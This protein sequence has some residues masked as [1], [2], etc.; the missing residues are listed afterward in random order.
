MSDKLT[1]EQIDDLP[2]WAEENLVHH[3]HGGDYNND[4]GAVREILTRA[5]A[6]IRH[7]QEQTEIAL[8]LKHA[9]ED[10]LGVS[11]GVVRELNAKLAQPTPAPVPADDEPVWGVWEVA[12]E[13]GGR[14]SRLINCKR[15]AVAEAVKRCPERPFKV[16]Y[17]G[18]HGEPIFVEGK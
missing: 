10:A 7:L 13:G 4:P 14:W 12:G 11:R 8:S 16:A 9:A 5:Q 3:K 18:P 2:A 15:A 17:R 6:T 1:Q